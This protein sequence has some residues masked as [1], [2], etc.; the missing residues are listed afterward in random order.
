MGRQFGIAAI[1]M[2]IVKAGLDHCDFGVVGD[3]QAG[4]AAKVSERA[5]MGIHPVG[6]AFRPARPGKGQAGSTHDGHEDMRLA[7][8]TRQPVDHHGHRVSGI[9]DEHPV[10]AQMRLPNGDRQ[11]GL[12][13][14]V[15]LTKTAVSIPIGMQL[16]ILVP[17]SVR[18]RGVISGV[19]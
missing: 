12:P 1:D 3:Q 11:P 5:D 8:F 4:R 15:E 16:D 7:D 14:P 17:V 2:R 19:D 18:A 9:V 10:A 6:Q 13:A